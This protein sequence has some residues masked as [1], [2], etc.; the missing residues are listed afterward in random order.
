MPRTKTGGAGVLPARRALRGGRD[1]LG[2]PLPGEVHVW[3]ASLDEPAAARRVRRHLAPDEL[4]RA[5]RFVRSED[6]VRS[7]VARGIL[8]ELLSGYVGGAPGELRFEY[9]CACGVAG[10]GLTRRKPRLAGGLDVRFN[11]AHSEGL[12]LFAFASRRE[13]GVDLERIRARVD[14]TAVAE[15]FLAPAEARA[16]DRLAPRARRSAFFRCWTRKEAYVKAR[17]E[18]LS[19][20]FDRFEVT[21]APH[22]RVRLVDRDDATAA[23]RFTLVDLGGLAG[24]A[25]ALAVEGSIDDLRRFTVAPARTA[26]VGP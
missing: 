16:L 26:R 1:A 14:R 2:L 21:L 8:R 22:E 23:S 17:G 3:C 19:R 12:A 5:A 10:C 25:A 4:A 9:P 13:V 20:P 24:F 15:Q 7:I 6:R 11:V 18:G